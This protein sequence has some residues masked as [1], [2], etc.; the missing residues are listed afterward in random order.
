MYVRPYWSI[1]G[2]KNLV[3]L[4][5]YMG[6]MSW[7]IF[8]YANINYTIQMENYKIQMENHT[9]QINIYTIQMENYRIQMEIIEYE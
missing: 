6:I 1:P 5:S 9:I 7:Y 2:L 3:R 8:L 4:T